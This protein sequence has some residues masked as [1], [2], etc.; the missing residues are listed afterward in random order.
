MGEIGAL[1]VP[2]GQAATNFAVTNNGK[3][4]QTLT[5]VVTP[6]SSQ[7]FSYN[8][9][10]FDWTQFETPENFEL[11]WR[12]LGGAED[13][14]S[15]A[16]VPAQRVAQTMGV[17]MST[18]KFEAS[19]VGPD[20]LAKAQAMEALQKAQNSGP[21]QFG[22]RTI[23]CTLFVF[24]EKYRNINDITYSVELEPTIETSNGAPANGTSATASLAGT[25]DAIGS[26]ILPP[27]L[28][29]LTAVPPA[30]AAAAS[31]KFP[32]AAL[33]DLQSLST[34]FQSAS[35]QL[36]T[37][38]SATSGSTL[39]SDTT[40]FLAAAGLV[41]QLS[42]ATATISQFTGATGSPVSA[43]GL[44][45]YQIATQYTGDINN[46]ESIMSANGISDPFNIGTAT[47]IIPS[48]LKAL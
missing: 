24:N 39:A 1:Q 5:S 17:V 31:T 29:Q 43:A 35:S 40:T 20:A 4:G 32:G 23:Q 25:L 37:L 7:Q 44:N 9:I 18:I 6:S 22:A 11:E 8:G 45:A 42:S 26:T 15:Q 46:V 34:T 48:I 38:M 13:I 3:G 16:G 30:I 10:S 47:V 33:S 12:T 21:F 36:N 2:A 19:F 28:A 27:A 41:G 14:P